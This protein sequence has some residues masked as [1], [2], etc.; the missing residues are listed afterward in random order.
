M[1]RS[2]FVLLVEDNTFDIDLSLRAFAKRGLRERIRVARD[3][4]EALAALQDWAAT[5]APLPSVILLDLHLPGL[6]G[7]EVLSRIRAQPGIGK[8]PVVVLTSSRD[9]WDVR[10]A[11][12]LGADSYLMKPIT[13]DAFLEVAEQLH[14]HWL[15][16]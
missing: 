13:A 8:I 16:A 2:G 4:E 14:L 10:K 1:D 15:E 5:G 7:L 3:G 11:H 12:L 6:G 9:H